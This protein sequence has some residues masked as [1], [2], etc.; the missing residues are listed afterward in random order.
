MFIST[1]R[2]GVKKT[3]VGSPQSLVLTDRTRS[4]GHKLKKEIL[5][6]CKRTLS[7]MRLVLWNK[8]PSGE[9][10]EGLSLDILKTWLDVVLSKLL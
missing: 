9:M 7:C 5:S 4:N 1:L 2:E 3:G 8:L 6:E 10:E